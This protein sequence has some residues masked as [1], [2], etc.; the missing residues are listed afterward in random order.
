MKVIALVTAAA[1]AVAAI[2]F[3]ATGDA[4][5]GAVAATRFTARFSALVFAAALVARAGRPPFL[6]ARWQSL[7]YAFVA[8]HAVH[9]GT[10]ATRAFVEPANRLRHPTLVP[11]LIIAGGLSLLVVLAGTR[12]RIQSAVFYLAGTLLVLALGS[13]AAT[14]AQ[15]P[16]S[17]ITLA[18]LIAAFAW[19][20]GG[21]VRR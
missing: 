15:H 14:P 1:V 9:Y 13:R 7:T 6:A 10:V 21:A 20:I 19:R 2:C 4:L 16:T 11:S 3:F 12:G 17:T 18:I 8:A 5:S